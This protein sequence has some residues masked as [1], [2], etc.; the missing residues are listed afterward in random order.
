[1]ELKRLNFAK[2]YKK[3]IKEGLKRQTIRLSTSL[4]EGEKVEV[5]AGGEVLGIAKITRVE[6]KTID[7][8]TDEDA[9]RDG[10]ENVAQLL[11]A[12]RRHYGRISNKK[13]VCVIGFEI[14]RREDGQ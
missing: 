10:F 2:E 5:V 8:L 14:E 1:M 13:E 12:L 3:K 9:K 7:E 4:R 11:K 6:R